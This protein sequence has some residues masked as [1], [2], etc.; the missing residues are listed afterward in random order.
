MQHLHTNPKYQELLK[1]GYSPGQI[2]DMLLH[3]QQNAHLNQRDTYTGPSQ[4]S[5]YPS[6]TFTTIPPSP[7]VDLQFHSIHE[8]RRMEAAMTHQRATNSNHITPRAP[9]HLQPRVDKSAMESVFQ[10]AFQARQQDG[11]LRADQHV[12]LLPDVRN[13][14]QEPSHHQVQTPFTATPPSHPPSQ[15]SQNPPSQPSQHPHAQR[16]AAY[17]AEMTKLAHT[18]ND[19][20]VLLKISPDYDLRTLAKAYRKA[21]LKYHPDRL[22]RKLNNQLTPE[23]ESNINAMFEKVTKAY[24]L[25]MNKYKRRQTDKPFNELRDQSK[26]ALHEQNKSTEKIRLMKDDQFDLQL[27]N[28]IYNEH[29]LGDV[30]DDGHGN[31]LKKEVPTERQ[32]ETFFS[33]KFNRNVFNTTF[34]QLKR[35]DPDAR[36]QLIVRDE[37]DALILSESASNFA[38]LGSDSIH[39]FGGTSGDLEY[40]DLKEA[41]T[42]HAT[43]IHAEQVGHNT[44]NDVKALQAHRSQLSHQRSEADLAR[45]ALHAREIAY[46]EQAR[47][48]RLA[49]QDQLAENQHARLGGLLMQ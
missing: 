41:H 35:D 19:A 26:Q 2:T 48:T 14:P 37:P 8:S 39:D 21:A 31:W 40:S 44:F 6:N 1:R 49:R 23:Q 4:P 20:F 38:T 24:L 45:D 3:Y 33:G 15:P 36:K 42:T 27:F 5:T 28:R 22:R 18:E 30:Y 43:L 47:Q 32:T 46:A 17:Q 11:G 10:Q 9:M 29:R 16:F 12:P 7:N 13:Y 34:E 25:L